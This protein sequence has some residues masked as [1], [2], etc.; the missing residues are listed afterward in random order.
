VVRAGRFKGFAESTE[1]KSL[2]VEIGRGVRLLRFL[3]FGCLNSFFSL[4]FRKIVWFLILMLTIKDWLG[5][6][7]AHPT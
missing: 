2:G 7:E 1:A 6:E 3:L 5:A 4:I